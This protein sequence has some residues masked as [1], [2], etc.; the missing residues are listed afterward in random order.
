MPARDLTTAGTPSDLGASV[1]ELLATQGKPMGVRDIVR[2]LGLDA[3]GRHELKDELRR[4]IADR[5]LVKVHG[6]RLGRPDPGNL[7][8]GVLTANPDGL[9]FV[10]PYKPRTAPRRRQAA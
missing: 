5:Q 2:R 3:P 1:L 8:E 10:A 9:G 6:A 7:L 4:L